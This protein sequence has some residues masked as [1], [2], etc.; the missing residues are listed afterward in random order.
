MPMK[1]T[2][3]SNLANPQTTN[4]ETLRL[5]AVLALVSYH[6]VGSDP[7]SGL[8]LGYPHYLRIFADGLIDI[9]MPLLL[10]S[11]DGSTPISPLAQAASA[12]F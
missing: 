5:I 6:A 4:E 7:S 10:S 12:D 2:D 1:Q 9:R 11:P 8:D 3:P